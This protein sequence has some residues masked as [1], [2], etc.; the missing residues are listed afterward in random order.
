[1]KKIVLILMLVLSSVSFSS[2]RKTGTHNILDTDFAVEIGNQIQKMLMR[3]NEKPE[4]IEALKLGKLGYKINSINE[5]EEFLKMRFT[6]NGASLH[7]ELYKNNQAY[8]KATKEFLEDK[9]FNHLSEKKFKGKYKMLMLDP[10]I[11]S[12]VYGKWSALIG[13]Y[14]IIKASARDFGDSDE[15]MKEFFYELEK[16][17]KNFK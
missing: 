6:V 14:Q 13:E 15:N 3:K 8:N 11:S 9:F 12:P 2:Q 5:T 7:Y 17:S 10:V 4:L 1:M 16:L